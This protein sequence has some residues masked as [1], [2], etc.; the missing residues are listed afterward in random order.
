MLP[1]LPESRLAINYASKPRSGFYSF[2]STPL[3]SLSILPAS[4]AERR[5]RTA[6]FPDD[7]AGLSPSRGHSFSISGTVSDADSHERVE[8]VRVD[9]QGLSGGILATEFTGSSGNFE[10]TNVRLGS[11]QLVFQQ[12]GYQD[13][14]QEVEVQGPVF[15]MNVA[16]RKLVRVVRAAPASRCASFPCRRK[17][18]MP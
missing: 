4:A 12:V 3:V 2:D 16:L 18:A 17:R 14:R 8:G 10:F 9:L 13:S 7:D 6:P 15:A 5:P 1:D 11:Y